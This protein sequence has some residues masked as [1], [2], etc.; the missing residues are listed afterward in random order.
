MASLQNNNNIS[1]DIVYRV[2]SPE[3]CDNTGI[4]IVCSWSMAESNQKSIPGDAQK[5]ST[6]VIDLTSSLEK[7]SDNTN[8]QNH[9]ETTPTRNQEVDEDTQE[10]T[11]SSTDLSSLKRPMSTPFRHQM[12]HVRL[13]GLRKSFKKRRDWFKERRKKPAT[14][15]WKILIPLTR[16]R[17]VTT[18]IVNVKLWMGARGDTSRQQ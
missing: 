8:D 18:K 9:G 15:V 10:S 12:D 17:K 16:H 7:Q 13:R 5:K 1:P 4:T 6:S 14:C 11:V 3:E 2:K